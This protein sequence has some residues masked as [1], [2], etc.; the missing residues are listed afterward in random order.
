MAVILFPSAG[1]GYASERVQAPAGGRCSCWNVRDAVA[2]A[3]SCAAAATSQT[4]KR[5]DDEQWRQWTMT[6]A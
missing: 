2:L 6:P 3:E 4:P 1:L 5:E